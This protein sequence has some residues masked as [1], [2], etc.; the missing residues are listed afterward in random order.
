VSNI[1]ENPLSTVQAYH[2]AWTNGDIDE[3]LTY[4]S[5]D[6]VCFAPDKDVT[7][8]A[9]WRDYLGS[10]VPMLT[11]T[12]EHTRMTDGARVALWYYPQTAATTTTL[13]SELFTV[14][15]GQITEIR[16]AFDRLGYIPQEQQP[17]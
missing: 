15:E 7:T 13:A 10:F 14:R 1:H 6:V 9:D 16:L 8:K 12:P 3:A 5:D 2:Q 17:A 11:G 4:V